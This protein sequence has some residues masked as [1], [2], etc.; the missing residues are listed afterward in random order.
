[1][2]GVLHAAGVQLL[3]RNQRPPLRVAFDVQKKVHE[4][5]FLQVVDVAVPQQSSLRSTA[6]GRLRSTA[7]GLLGIRRYGWKLR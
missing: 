1:M 7:D 6:F 2:A 5:W 4:V 3:C